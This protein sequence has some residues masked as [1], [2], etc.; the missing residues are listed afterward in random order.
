LKRRAAYGCKTVKTANKKNA[1]PSWPLE[2]LLRAFD[3]AGV[4]YLII[5]GQA[6]VVYGASQF[7]QDADL[8]AARNAPLAEIQA[9]MDEEKSMYQRAN[10]DYWKPLLKELREIRREIVMARGD[11]RRR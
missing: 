6:A 3:E 7:T 1:I 9:A 2:R 10:R 4:K 5:G 8:L 11:S